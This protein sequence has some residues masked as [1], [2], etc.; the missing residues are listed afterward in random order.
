MICTD[1]RLIGGPGG[2]LDV[3]AARSCDAAA[4]SG[5]QGH[6]QA[7]GVDLL[8]TEALLALSRESVPTSW[9]ALFPP[10]GGRERHHSSEDTE[11]DSHGSDRP[12][13][14]RPQNPRKS[15]SQESESLPAGLVSS[16]SDGVVQGVLD[17]AAAARRAA[18]QRMVKIESK[19]KTQPTKNNRMRGPRSGKPSKAWIHLQQQQLERME[20]R[21]SLT[22]AEVM[23]LQQLAAHLRQ[24]E[25]EE[26]REMKQLGCGMDA[27]IDLAS[28]GRKGEELSA[29]SEVEQ[30]RA[31]RQA[32]ERHLKRARQAETARA[33]GEESFPDAKARKMHDS[34]S[35]GPEAPMQ[36]MQQA[37]GAAA[38]APSK[39]Q[40]AKAATP[41][42]LT[43]ELQDVVR[44]W[45]L[46]NHS[47]SLQLHNLQLQNAL[48]S[49][50]EQLLHQQQQGIQPQQ[51]LQLMAS[52][53]SSRFNSNQSSATQ[54]LLAHASGS[55]L[56]LLPGSGATP[57][58]ASGFLVA[59]PSQL[60]VQPM[61]QPMQLQNM[62]DLVIFEVPPQAVGTAASQ[63]N[64]LF[65]RGGGFSSQ[66]VAE[67]SSF[68][69]SL[70]LQQRQQQQQVLHLQ[71][72]RPGGLVQSLM[73]SQAVK[74][75]G[76]GQPAAF[77]LGHGSVCPPAAYPSPSRQQQQ[78]QMQFVVVDWP[79]ADPRLASGPAPVQRH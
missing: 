47:Q 10:K 37:K 60:P 16:N 57:Q 34:S 61:Q 53:S 20:K 36:R 11:S 26:E 30:L 49:R 48:L 43:P 62:E 42:L 73:H 22:A 9:G 59:A 58:S 29:L 35:P 19:R 50:Q 1:V 4:K 69:G 77:S 51:V 6:P 2:E 28:S 66:L 64:A 40:Q 44:A 24:K 55:G 52:A 79:A 70:A 25:E 41:L 63:H 7:A 8:A 78:Q 54:H 75:E 71:T 33:G 31:L 76:G 39:T 65:H 17:E 74:L 38:P 3:P 14:Q 12:F 21:E 45:Q 23:H 46:G 72:A 5:P 56:T 67:P 32:A 15:V 13:Q 27:S 68:L 18:L